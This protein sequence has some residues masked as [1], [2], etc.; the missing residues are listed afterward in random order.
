MKQNSDTESNVGSNESMQ[1][2][3]FTTDERFREKIGGSIEILDAGRTG[4]N[5]GYVNRHVI[6]SNV[7][8]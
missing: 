7:S 1:N 5:S 4:R 3:P 8:T 2:I 6:R